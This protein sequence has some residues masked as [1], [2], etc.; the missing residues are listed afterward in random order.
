MGIR[1]LLWACP[2]CGE[3]RALED[4]D[5][6][7]EAVCRACGTAFARVRGADIEARRKDGSTEVRT[8]A[9]W[10]ERL[11]SPGAILGQ[12]GGDGPVRTAEARIAEVVGE[13]VV[14]VGGDYLNRVEVWGEESPGTVELWPDRLVIGRQD[15]DPVVWPLETLTAVQTSSKTLQ[16]KARSAP[17]TSFRFVHDASLLWERLLHAALRDFYGRTGRGEI[18]EFQPRITAAR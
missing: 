17:L 16:L 5:G 8:A 7:K 3:D 14:R 12:G 10:L 2:L 1:S 9:D 15:E 13:E 11:P 4:G 6:R 18:V